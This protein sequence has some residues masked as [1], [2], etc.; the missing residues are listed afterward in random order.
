[1]AIR[2]REELIGRAV[3]DPDFRKRLLE[4]PDGTIR[5]EGF[6]IDAETLAKLKQIDP[7][8]A[9]EA[10]KNLDETFASRAAGG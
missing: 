8:A 6:Q 5:A 3:T 9:E 7:V 10:A 4:D 2:G 1:M